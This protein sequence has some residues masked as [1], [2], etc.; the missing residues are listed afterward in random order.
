MPKKPFP[1]RYIF[2]G[3]IVLAL[4]GGGVAAGVM[5]RPKEEAPA[6]TSTPTPSPTPVQRVTVPLATQT[7]YTNLVAAAATLSASINKLQVNDTTLSP[8]VIELSLGFP[9]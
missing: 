4:V 2:I 1:M 7:A 8:P 9:N 6:P 5:L 3:I